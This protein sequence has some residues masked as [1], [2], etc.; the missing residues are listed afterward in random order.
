MSGLLQRLTWG[1]LVAFSIAA[2]A[3]RVSAAERITI[4]AG[5][6]GGG[7]FLAG[8]ALAEYIKTDMK[9]QT[10]VMPGGGWGNVERLQSKF[11]D[12]AVLENAVVTMATKGE[13]PNKQKY[14][15][16]ML[17]SFRGPNVGQAAIVNS[18][19]IKKF[20]DIVARKFPLRVVMLSPADHIISTTAVDTMAA[21]GITK[22]AVES[23]GGKFIYTSQNDGFS[24]IMDGRADMFFL[25]AGYYPHNKYM[26]LGT[27]SAFTLLPISKEAAQKVA[28]KYGLDVERVPADIYK[29]SN[30]TNAEYWSPS[31]VVTFAVR[32][33]M[34]DEVVYA[35]AKALANHKEEFWKVAAQHKFYDPSRAWKN[36]GSAPLHPGA[37][38][39]YQEMGYMK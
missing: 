6:P 36:I 10:T 9:V 18:T 30:G 16:R 34:K 20:E 39:F 21:Y 37:K 28:D 26:E 4:T 27:K 31:L 22:E 14:D 11:A 38:K 35:V 8:A 2:T 23:W 7:Y 29:D 19:G 25:G 33:D 24:M 32:T 3:A 17:A 15:F 1:L 13:G 5:S 12:I